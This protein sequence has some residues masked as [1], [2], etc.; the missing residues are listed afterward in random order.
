MYIERE[1]ERAMEGKIGR[2]R[3]FFVLIKKI[4]ESIYTEEPFV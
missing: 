1:R 4:Q 3:V 2:L